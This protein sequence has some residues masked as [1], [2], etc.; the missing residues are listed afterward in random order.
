MYIPKQKITGFHG[1]YPE[2]IDSILANNFY[3][4][5]NHDMWIGDGVY[6]FVDGI[7]ALEPSLYAKQYAIDSCYDKDGKTY[8]KDE[9]C[10]LEAVIKI[11]N[12]RY[13]D[14]TEII[15][16]QLFNT[17]RKRTISKIEQSGKRPIS[18][19]YNDADVFKIMRE[20]LGI[21]F[22]KSN[23]YIKFA[24]QRIA[25]FE[26]RIPNVTILV[27]NNPIKHIQKPTIKVV[28]KVKIK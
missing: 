27:V 21:E 25:R 13:L 4:S 9:V 5:Q 8:F 23:V 26:S 24:V 11:N 10:V 16:S 17:F 3:E 7:G 18:G 20:E 15:G 2:N 28:Q 19:E 12:D 1:T 6:F 22:V 14:L